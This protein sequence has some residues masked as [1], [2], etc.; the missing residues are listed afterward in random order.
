MVDEF[1]V[2]ERLVPNLK[3]QY[4]RQCFA[5]AITMNTLPDPL[6]RYLQYESRNPFARRPIRSP[7]L[8]LLLLHPIILMPLWIHHSYGRLAFD[9]ASIG[10]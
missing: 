10:G 8:P 3:S 5:V 9:P 2:H 1:T 4:I 7:L 6:L